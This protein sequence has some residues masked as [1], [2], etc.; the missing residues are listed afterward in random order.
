MIYCSLPGTARGRAARRAAHAVTVGSGGLERRAAHA[1]LEL[2]DAFADPWSVRA[3]VAALEPRPALGTTPRHSSGPLPAVLPA[4][5][6]TPMKAEPRSARTI[7]SRPWSVHWHLTKAGGGGA[8]GVH[9]TSARLAGGQAS[10][11]VVRRVR[12]PVLQEGPYMQVALGCLLRVLGPANANL[13]VVA[14]GDLGAK[15]PAGAAG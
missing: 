2:D 14:H 1:S 11:P 7:I 13:G 5:T 10:A 8:A 3:Y 6:P 4:N 15:Q 12:F 9:R